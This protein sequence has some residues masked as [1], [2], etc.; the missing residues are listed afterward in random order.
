MK[1]FRKIAHDKVFFLGW[2]GKKAI[3]FKKN[4][5]TTTKWLWP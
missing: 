4:G 2:G 3:Y 5:G 1:D